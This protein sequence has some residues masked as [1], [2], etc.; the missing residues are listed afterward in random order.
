MH[1]FYCP[2]LTDG[3]LDRDESHHA[4]SVLRM[5][6]GDPCQLFDGKGVEAT[7]KLSRVHKNRVL[8]EILD[9]RNSPYKKSRLVL[10]Q[11]IPKAKAM[12]LILQK[13]TELGLDELHPIAS[14]HSV[15]HLDGERLECKTEK[16]NQILVEA[17]KQCGRNILPVLHPVSGLP[18]FLAAHA[19]AKG[20]KL[21]ASL[22]KNALPLA[23]A[24]E[25][26]KKSGP[27]H[28][29]IFL[30]G[31]EGDFTAVEIDQA[32]AAGYVPVTLGDLTLRTET[33]ALFLISVLSHE[34]SR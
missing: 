24:L 8:F 12:D 16:W 15:V 27:L 18:D 1:R 31:P 9:R 4:A 6:E 29:I 2:N 33:A 30:V 14:E 26:A 7:V 3:F 32:L 19:P 23:A 28:E 34:F 21:V 13:A 22:Q 11:A 20:L 5:K 25:T 17:C 10:G